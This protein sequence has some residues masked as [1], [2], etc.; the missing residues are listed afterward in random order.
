MISW[1]WLGSNILPA[2]LQE[3]KLPLNRHAVHSSNFTE[4]NQTP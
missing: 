4:I 2:M 3:Q 1:Y